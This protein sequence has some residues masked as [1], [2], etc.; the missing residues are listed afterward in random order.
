MAAVGMDISIIICTFNGAQRLPQTLRE[1][2]GSRS[3]AVAVSVR[4]SR[5]GL[6]PARN[7]GVQ[8][9]MGQS[10]VF[11][12]DDVEVDPGR[13]RHLFSAA[14]E[15]PD[16]VFWRKS[17]APLGSAAAPVVGAA[18]TDAAFRRGGALR[19]GRC[20]QPDERRMFS[21]P[22]WPFARSVRPRPLCVIMCQRPA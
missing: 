9:D 14:A 7:R 16:A 1:P 6:S 4:A 22:T 12:D 5:Q 15:P 17:A 18:F 21:E 20:L 2:P 13:L 19:P 3:T 10:V 11:T 8:E